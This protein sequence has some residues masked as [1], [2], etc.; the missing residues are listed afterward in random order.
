[1][2]KESDRLPP[3]DLLL[4]FEAAAR[5]LS[6]TRAGAERYVTQSAISRQIRALEDELGVALFVR[7]HRA[8]ELTPDGQ[9]LLLACSAVLA[10]LRKTVASIRAPAQREV[11]ALS[12]TPSFASLW[13]IPRLLSFTQAHPGVDVRLDA[14]FDVR[15]LRADGFDLAVRYA[16]S[17]STEGRHLFG[18]TM[19]PVCAPALLRAKGM[20]LKS[21]EDL[22]HHTVLQ[23]EQGAIGGMPMEWALWLRANALPDLQ[24]RS[25]L[26]FSNYNEVIAAALAGQGVALGRRP[27]ID[28]LLRQRRLAAPFG[29]ARSTARAYFVVSDA[30]A[31]SR[32]AVRALEDWLIA[33]AART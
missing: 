7:R 20:P 8:L 32:P 1:M 13:L 27:L 14:S 10:Q 21:P 24:P 5:H 31:R 17:N 25:T 12:T 15:D 16:P 22:R 33:E 30:L 6:F 2:R 18:E 26:T 19:L 4:A 3:L 29:D 9:K 11:L 23:M 28:A